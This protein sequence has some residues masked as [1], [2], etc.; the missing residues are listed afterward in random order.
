MT[1]GSNWWEHFFEGL[2]VK[3]WLEALSPEHSNSEA[4]AIARLLCAPP[5]ACAEVRYGSHQAYRY[6][7]LCELITA[8]GF[9]AVAFLREQHARITHLHLKD[10]R[11]P[12]RGAANVA[13]G[14]GDTPIAQ[15]LQLIS[16]EGWDIPANIEFEYPGDPLVEVPKCFQYCKDALG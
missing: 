12:A 14:D 7:E 9:D 8:A 4:D 15:V 3:L 2:S 16:R 11:T 1:I 13:W 6:R 10:R 5:D